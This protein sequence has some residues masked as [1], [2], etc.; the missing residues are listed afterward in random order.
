MDLYLSNCIY[1]KENATLTVVIKHGTPSPVEESSIWATNKNDLL[2]H[3]FVNSIKVNVH[4]LLN[5][6]FCYAYIFKKKKSQFL[7]KKK[8]F[9]FCAEIP[10]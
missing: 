7:L 2:L 8:M 1:A 4:S 5:K 10:P 6:W 3:F 9:F